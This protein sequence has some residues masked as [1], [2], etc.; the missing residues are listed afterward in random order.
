MS[1]LVQ[2]AEISERTKPEAGR[3]VYLH[4]LTITIEIEL[5]IL[6]TRL[7]IV[8]VVVVV[9]QRRRRRIHVL[10]FLKCNQ[11]VSGRTRVLLRQTRT[12]AR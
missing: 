9:G 3:S 1:I 10:M 11:I 6:A 8:Q 5:A 4:L 7:V 12:K 2:Q